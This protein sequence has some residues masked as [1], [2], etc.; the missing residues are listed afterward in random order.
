[1]SLFDTGV[2]SC[3]ANFKLKLSRTHDVSIGP[4]RQLS[5][6]WAGSSELYIRQNTK[7]YNYIH[8]S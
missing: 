7:C 5:I 3:Q 6:L 2:L 8:L 4:E 1:M